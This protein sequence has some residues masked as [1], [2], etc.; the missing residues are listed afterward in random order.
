MDPLD[1]IDRMSAKTDAE[2]QWDLAC[3]LLHEFGIEW[4]SFG[5]ALR[6]HTDQ[7]TVAT[8][9]PEGMIA[10]YFASGLNRVDPWLQICAAAPDVEYCVPMHSD[11]EAGDLDDRLHALFAGHG[12][13]AAAL[14]PAFSGKTVGG[15]VGYATCKTGSELM[16]R[17]DLQSDMRLSV[18]LIGTALRPES[19][20]AN[21]KAPVFSDPQL[22]PRER[23]TLTWLAGGNRID[24]IGEKMGIRP[25]TVAKHLTSART[26]LRARTREEAL[27]IA[28]TRRLIQ[29]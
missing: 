17:P 10:D 13:R 23:E 29:P 4:M 6:T 25:V 7:P 18:A 24:R 19:L 1:I 14:I 28:I 27:A 8:S 20:F 9:A 21:G 2:G 26:K 11:P 22:T 3:R 15:V 16:L 12:I 5:S